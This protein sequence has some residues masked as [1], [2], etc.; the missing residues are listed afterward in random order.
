MLAWRIYA[1]G[2]LARNIAT[3]SAARKILLRTVFRGWRRVAHRRV[4]LRSQQDMLT[5]QQ[6]LI[7]MKRTLTVWRSVLHRTLTLRGLEQRQAIKAWFLQWR[8]QASHRRTQRRQLGLALRMRTL[9]LATWCL[10]TWCVRIT[11]RRSERETKKVRSVLVRGAIKRLR[12]SAQKGRRQRKISMMQSEGTE[13]HM[14]I[15]FVRWRRLARSVVVVQRLK[16][17]RELRSLVMAF[18][19]WRAYV[20]RQRLSHCNH[21]VVTLL[22]HCCCTIITLLLHYC[23]TVVTSGR[24]QKSRIFVRSDA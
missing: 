7:H 16:G 23:Y 24:S 15:L 1:E 11:E 2:R 13:R 18:G 22:S 21:R 17:S 8:V 19:A 6:R 5:D 14:R 3:A 9:T 10:N 20:A 4:A 12:V